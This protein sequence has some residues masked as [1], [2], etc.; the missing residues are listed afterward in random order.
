MSMAVKGRF[1]PAV[2]ED[3]ETKSDNRMRR[4]LRQGKEL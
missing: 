1:L 2:V 4:N 3:E